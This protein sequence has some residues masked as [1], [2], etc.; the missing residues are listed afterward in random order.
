M[1]FFTAEADNGNIYRYLLPTE[2]SK[3]LDFATKKNETHTRAKNKVYEYARARKQ[4][5]LR[6]R[7]RSQ[8]L[9]RARTPRAHART[10]AKA[11]DVTH[12]RARTRAKAT[13]L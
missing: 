4:Q 7:A 11:T 3:F 5:A 12:A 1:P 9:T 2:P 6:T 13:G 10:R 8:C